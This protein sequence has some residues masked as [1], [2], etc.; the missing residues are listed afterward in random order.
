MAGTYRI[1]EHPSDLGI[2][3]EAASAPEAFAL[4]AEGLMSVIVDLR[5]VE[6]RVT[7]ELRLPGSDD[8]RLLVRWLGEVLFL[9]DGAGFVPRRFTV[10]GISPRGLQAEAAGEPLDTARHSLKLDVKAVT[11]HGVEVK[12]SAAGCSL[13]VYLD[14]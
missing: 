11:Y 10:T 6:A 2:E 7:R 14:I 13:R 1:I 12:R 5:T 4:A 9:Y 8:E 3:V